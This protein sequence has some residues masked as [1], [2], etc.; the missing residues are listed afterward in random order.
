MQGIEEEEMG[1]ILFYGAVSLDGYLATKED[2]LQW[3]FDTPTGIGTTYEAFYK[4]ID[5]TVM[6]RRTYEEAKKYLETDALYPDKRNI[7]FSSNKEL[8]LEDATVVH[9]DPVGVVE[10]LK[11]NP[12]TT[13]WMVGGGTL[14]R[15]LIEHQLI[16]EWYIQIAPVLLGNGIRL[17]QE[18]KYEERLKLTDSQRFGEFIELHYIKNQ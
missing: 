14:L 13:V 9:E 17:F 5:V 12:D 10:Q 8:K 18:G 6:G 16:D 15:P 3:L 1:R 4:Q 2:S 11:K 7:V